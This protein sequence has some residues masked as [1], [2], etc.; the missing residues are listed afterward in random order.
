MKNIV[1]GQIACRANL[2]N[3]LFAFRLYVHVLGKADPFTDYIEL[4]L[5]FNLY[6]IISS[7]NEENLSMALNTKSHLAT[8]KQAS[9]VKNSLWRFELSFI[10][11]CAAVPQPLQVAAVHNCMFHFFILLFQSVSV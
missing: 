11:K 7:I 5:Y 2:R 8:G 1:K 9:A 10:I 6:T 4:I 3:Y